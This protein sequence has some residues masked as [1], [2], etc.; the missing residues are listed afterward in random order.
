[1]SNYSDFWLKDNHYEWDW[2]DELDAAIEEE[3]GTDATVDAEDRLSDTTA[4]LIRLSSARRAV[5]NYVSILT[6]QNIPVVFNDSAV[7]CTD[8][9]LVYISSDITKKDNFDVAVG[10]AL[11]EGSHIKYSD[12]ELFKT[13]WMNVPRD[14]YNYTEK[15]S[16]SKDE[17]GKTCQTILNY[18]E[19]RFIDYT[20]HRNAPGYR[21]YYDALYDE[22]FNNKVISD[23]LDSDMYRTLSIDS[24]MYRIINLTN[25]NTNLKALP[26]LYDIAKELDLTNISRLTTPKDRLNV[27]YKIAE[28]V[29][30][31]INEHNQKQTGPG[32]DQN[33]SGVP[34]NSNG[35]PGDGESGK[36]TDDVLGGTESTVTSDNA[37]VTSD[38]G[39][40]ANVSKTKQSKIAKSFEKQKDFLAG[41]IKKKKVSKREKTMLDVLEKSQIDLVPVAQE[42]MKASGFV[43]SVECILVKNMTKELILS[44]EFPMSIGANNESSRTELQKNVDAGI[45]LGT[46]LGRRLQIRNEINI[47]KFTRRN[48]GKID[49]RLMHELGFETDTNIFYS[50]FTNKYKKV[51]FHISVDASAS[52]RGPKWNRTIKLCVALAKAT[53]MIDN[54]DLT[55]SFR[56]TMSYNP[57][58]VVAYNSKVDKFSKIK[59]LFSYLIPVNTTP[60]GLCFE[61]LMKFLPKAD[62]NTNSYFVNISDGEPCFYYNNTSA[63][64][65]FSYRDKSACEHTRTQVRKIKESGY[66]I[67]SYFVSDYDSFGMEVLRQNFKT[68][69]GSD[70]HFINVENLNQIVKT[71]NGK[72]MEAIDI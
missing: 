16:I 32:F 6:N 46:K 31:N 56:T 53:S 50:T 59:N 3:S 52:M 49:K 42:M 51:N 23:A 10:L 17:V 7:N 66:N 61:A 24:Y 67:I 58:I 2:E 65:A 45:V 33:D 36:S 29:F 57:Y 41:K 55:I 70:S 60:E 68:M 18:V 11:H 43:G 30:K 20:V 22:Y 47:D 4:R 54:V 38:V 35:M 39:T 21:G 28:I 12:F 1:M 37:A 13:V 44:E 19:D 15:L 63:G 64:I 8:G 27:A 69:Y 34:D 40:D 5:A 9:K 48:L 71:V 62:T 25:P 72:M 26:G 14:I